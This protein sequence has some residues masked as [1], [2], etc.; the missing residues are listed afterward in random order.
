MK[1]VE[2]DMLLLKER[3]LD[4]GIPVVLGEFG[5]STNKDPASVVKYLSTVCAAAHSMGVVPVLWDPASHYDR[6]ALKWTNPQ[7]GEALA[8]I[9]AD[10]ANLG[11]APKAKEPPQNPR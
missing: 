3:F 1:T 8:R 2:S 7:V 6:R 9:A 4:K 10:D 5:C 11:A